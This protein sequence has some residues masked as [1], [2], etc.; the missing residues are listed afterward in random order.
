[1]DEKSL[2]AARSA[3]PRRRP[4]PAWWI[5]GLLLAVT[6]VAAFAFSPADRPPVGQEVTCA[7]AA[8]SLAWDFDL[9][10]TPADSQRFTA[11]WGVR[12]DRLALRPGEEGFTYGSP[13]LYALVAAPFTRLAP[14][15][16]PVI[17]NVL[18]LL[19]AALLAARALE[20][21]LGRAAPLWVAVW[22][23]ASVVFAYVF[24]VQPDLF[25]MATT[26]AG[27]AL[28]YGGERAR[29]SDEPMPDIY[30][31]E[32]IAPQGRT[33]GRWLGAGLLLAV[34]ATVHPLYLLLLLPALLAAREVPERRRRLLA[35]S[36]LALGA[37]SLL[38]AVLLL[39]GPPRE[40]WTTWT[41]EARMYD[42]R[43]GEPRLVSQSEES[44]A[45]LSLHP[46][47]AGWNAL[48][49]LAGRNVGVLPYFLPLV[50]GFAAYRGERG[51]WALLLVVLLAAAG[52]LLLRPF[53][54]IGGEGAIANRLFL[55]LYAALWFLAARPGRVFPALLVAALA[56]PFLYP[57]WSR[58]AQVSLSVSPMAARWLPYETTQQHAPGEALFQN[59]LW[60]K[61]LTSGVWHPNGADSLRLLGDQRVELLAGRSQPLEGFLLEFDS[62]APSHLSIGGGRDLRPTL[63]RPDGSVVFEVPAGAPR[64][65]HPL[66]WSR[67]EDYSLYDLDFRLPGAKPVPIR[68][69]VLPRRD[70]MIQRSRE[71]ER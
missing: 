53:D 16:G 14:V 65:V 27:F 58:P 18:L 23:F 52:F 6:L 43:G 10:W 15:R 28:V 62:H 25:L 46:R 7:M 19:G 21:R 36:G 61:L 59:S 1:M 48:Y 44:E 70:L 34:P 60:L 22:I 2:E 11:Q 41:T 3:A 33:F 54:F 8:A 45:G 57:L 32:P 24:R 69:R 67:G 5:L 4:E 17:A 49:F 31:G 50:L 66:W 12:P 35:L 56:A 9:A 47:L 51:R 30:E 55:P 20:S 13:V 26:A 68:F 40:V 63:L 38:A 71:S 39:Q 37:A 29:R 64:A 42:L